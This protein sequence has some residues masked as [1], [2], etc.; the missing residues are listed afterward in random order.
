M[1]IGSA[2][3]GDAIA[4]SCPP[5]RPVCRG[6]RLGAVVFFGCVFSITLISNPASDQ[7]PLHPFSTGHRA[8]RPRPRPPL[9]RTWDSVAGSPALGLLPAAVFAVH[10][11]VDAVVE[12]LHAPY[13]PNLKAQA[14][15]GFR[16]MFPF[17]RDPLRLCAVLEITH[18]ADGFWLLAGVAVASVDHLGV[19]LLSTS[20]FGVLIPSGTRFGAWRPAL[21]SPLVRFLLDYV[22]IV[23]RH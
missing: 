18:P 16:T 3:G 21:Q 20:I 5:V 12:E 19:S 14:A 8:L 17:L 15:A 1:S 11:A 4:G 6:T 7:T 13:R 22:V 9:G 2:T 10:G 23:D